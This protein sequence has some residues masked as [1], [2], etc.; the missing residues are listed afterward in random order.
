ML[1]GV[2]IDAAIKGNSYQQ[3]VQSFF[4]NKNKPPQGDPSSQ[5]GNYLPRTCF[6]CGQEGHIFRACPQRTL[7]SYPPNPAPPAVSAPQNPAPPPV[8]PRSLCSRCQRG[9]HWARN[10]KSRFHRNGTF[11]GPDQQSGNGLRGQPQALTTIGAASLNPF[12][13]FVPSQNSSEK[14]QAAQ[15]WTSVPPPQQC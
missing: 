4:T 7:G 3:A 15:D 1:Q 6:S 13:P 9:Y 12:I 14:P 8:N 5:G 11:L 2:A 10:C